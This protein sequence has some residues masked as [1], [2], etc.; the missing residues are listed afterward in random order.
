MKNV[1]KEKQKEGE[2][3]DLCEK[4]QNTNEKRNGIHH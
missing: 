3:Y 2:N 4:K 1:V